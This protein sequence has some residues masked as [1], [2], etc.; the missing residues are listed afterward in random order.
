MENLLAIAIDIL[1]A[2]PDCLLSGS[3][4]LRLQDVD[5][6][7]PPKDIDIYLPIGVEF[8]PIN[9]MASAPNTDNGDYPDDGWDR[10]EYIKDG[11]QIDIFTPAES[12]MPSMDSIVKNNVPMV[13]KRDIIK[14][15][16]SHAWGDHFTR[17]KHRN[18]IVFMMISAP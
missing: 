15:K 13:D 16:A 5:T 17:F 18:D 14:F 6:M 11:I 12:G 3:I 10:Y 8:T 1:K 7:R 4:A 2:N 9:G